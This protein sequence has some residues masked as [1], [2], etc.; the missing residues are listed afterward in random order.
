MVNN[1]DLYGLPRPVP[2]KVINIGGIGAKLKDAQPLP[3][4]FEKIMKRGKGT[5]L[6]SFGS[7]AQFQMAPDSW[8]NAVFGAFKRLPQYQFIVRYE[9]DYGR[10]RVE[11]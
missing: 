9:G 10:F 7:V 3:A 11:I 2:A 4:N 6:F 8:K 1:N 5:V